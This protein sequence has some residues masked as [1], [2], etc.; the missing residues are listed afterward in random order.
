[1]SASALRAG[2]SRSTRQAPGVRRPAAPPTAGPSTNRPLGVVSRTEPLAVGRAWPIILMAILVLVAA[3]AIPLV[4]NTQMA[5]TA[6]EIRDQQV[7]LAELQAEQ[8]VLEAQVLEAAS[9]E[10]LDAKARALGLTPVKKIGTLSLIDGTLT[11]G[12]PASE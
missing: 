2:T 6:H 8:A 12:E 1:M 10:S 11:G 4:V 3:I 7:E 5:Q 9:P